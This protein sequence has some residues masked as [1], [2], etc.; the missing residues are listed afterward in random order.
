MERAENESALL[1]FSF[2]CYITTLYTLSVR[3]EIYGENPTQDNE[4]RK[5]TYE[6]NKTANAR[7]QLENK[8]GREILDLRITKQGN[9]FRERYN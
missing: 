4:S 2:A 9:N 1:C 7:N 8:K 5:N 3:I 6:T